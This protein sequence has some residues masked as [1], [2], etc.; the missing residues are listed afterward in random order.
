MLIKSAIAA[1]TIIGVVLMPGQAGAR[2]L[3]LTPSHVYALWVNIN[4][5]LLVI[6]R[7]VSDDVSWR[8]TLSSMS[9]MKYEGKRPSDVLDRVGRLHVTIERLGPSAHLAGHPLEVDFRDV[10]ND[11][12]TPADVFVSSGHVLDRLVSWLIRNTGPEQ[13]VSGSYTRRTFRGKTPSD[14]F[15]LVGLADRRLEMILSKLGT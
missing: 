2:G 15:G 12:A 7:V 3:G 9:P 8:D 11:L 13:R 6:A 1:A 14:I 5:S 10:E 4:D